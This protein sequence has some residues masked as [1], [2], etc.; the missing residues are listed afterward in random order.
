MD[1]NF[2]VIID[3]RGISPPET[4]IM[5]GRGDIERLVEECKEYDR[6]R[7][8]MWSELVRLITVREVLR[9][10]GNVDVSGAREDAERKLREYA[11]ETLGIVRKGIHACTRLN[12]RILEVLAATHGVGKIIRDSEG[13]QYLK[14]EV[15]A[16]GFKPA[17]KV[18]LKD[19]PLMKYYAMSKKAV[20]G[21]VADNAMLASLLVQLGVPYPSTAGS[22]SE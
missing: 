6:K 2:S 4:C 14:Y 16:G 20:K 19:E 11:L 21:M 17:G 5:P 8:M 9:D 10:V 22:S 15:V 1:G 7:R 13:P 18:S 12:W 3:N